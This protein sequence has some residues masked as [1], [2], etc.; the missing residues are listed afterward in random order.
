MTTRVSGVLDQKLGYDT[1]RIKCN[2]N[3]DA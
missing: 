1:M 2:E 3:K